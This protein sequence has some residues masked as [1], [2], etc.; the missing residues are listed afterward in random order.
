MSGL[1]LVVSALRLWPLRA[2]RDSRMQLVL[3]PALRPTWRT[4]R[5][6]SIRAL[7]TAPAR[8]PLVE[9]DELSTR[10]YSRTM[11]WLGRRRVAER[12]RRIPWQELDDLLALTPAAFEEA[13]AAIYREY[14]FRRVV[15]TGRPGDLAADITCRDARGRL[16]VTAWDRQRSRSSS[17]WRIS[18]TRRTTQS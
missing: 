18:T 17:G 10:A 6:G 11:R 5:V 9:A 13:V 7:P 4:A 1:R 2:M 3:L 8:E 16:V 15:R 14:G 12:A